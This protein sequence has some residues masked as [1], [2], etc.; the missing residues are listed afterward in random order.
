MKLKEIIAGFSA[1]IAG[2]HK[3][4]SDSRLLICRECPNYSKRKRGL[5]YKVLPAH[6]LICNCFL[7]AKTSCG[8]C[9]CPIGKWGPEMTKEEILKNLEN[10]F[11]D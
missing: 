8:I 7:K 9:S 1:R 3:A 10:N 4:L 5:I 2:R 11:A 6:C